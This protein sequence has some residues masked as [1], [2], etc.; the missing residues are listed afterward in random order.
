MER[1]HCHRD[2]ICLDAWRWLGHSFPSSKQARFLVWASKMADN[3]C[4][5]ASLDA[6]IPKQ[7]NNT[8]CAK[9]T[10]L[11]QF[12][13]VNRYL[14]ASVL[15]FRIAGNQI[16][17]P[18]PHIWQP[19]TL[20]QPRLYSGQL[21]MA[22]ANIRTTLPGRRFMTQGQ[23]RVV[24]YVHTSSTRNTTSFV[25]RLIRM[26]PSSGQADSSKSRLTF[27]LSRK[28]WTVA[29]VC[30]GPTDVD[31]NIPGE[32]QVLC[33]SSSDSNCTYLSHRLTWRRV[34]RQKLTMVGAKH[35]RGAATLE[36]AALQIRAAS[37]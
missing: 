14:S 13:S 30:L 19:K 22:S 36:N 26:L 10:R 32:G 16:F 20:D 24:V 33:W 1:L 18:R 27:F 15:V 2:L 3:L 17:R 5:P 8:C 25:Q 9:G 35:H 28:C 7:A 6:P 31:S 29:Q 23:G 12:R 4:W 21:G 34:N 11:F 37:A